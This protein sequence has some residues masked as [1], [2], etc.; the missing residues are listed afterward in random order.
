[1]KTK[2]LILVALLCLAALIIGTIPAMP[3]SPKY[4]DGS[5]IGVVKDVKRG[6]TVV[7]VVIKSGKIAEVNV[8]MPTE[9]EVK[10]ENYPPALE[11]LKNIPKQI[12]AK[13]STDVDVVTKATGSSKK[14]IEA[15]KMALANAE[16][17]TDKLPAGV[18]WHDGTYAGLVRD[19]QHGDCVVEVVI[20]GGKIK[21]V[22]VIAPTAEYIK[23]YKYEPG[24]EAYKEIPKRILAAQ[25]PDVDV[26]TKA[27][28]SSKKYMEAVRH[29]LKQAE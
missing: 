1:M 3:A 16:P 22:N 13:Q 15:V 27:T 12:V 6:D 24:K 8:V 11:A 19:P 14:Y 18:K 17:K 21:E 20:K 23:N 2:S 9:E 26:Y 29:A 25:S 10:K 28:G 5:F 4:R 7:E